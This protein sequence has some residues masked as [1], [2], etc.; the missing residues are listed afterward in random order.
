MI[1]QGGIG[2]LEGQ[3]FKRLGNVVKRMDRLGI[4]FAHIMEMNLG[5]D[6]G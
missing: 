1:P 4:H 2:G 3:Q 6:T 5:M